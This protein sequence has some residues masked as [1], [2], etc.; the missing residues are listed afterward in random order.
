MIPLAFD[1]LDLSHQYQYDNIITHT[2]IP[3]DS[4]FNAEWFDFDFKINECDGFIRH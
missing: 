2:D 4:S 1:Q 3:E